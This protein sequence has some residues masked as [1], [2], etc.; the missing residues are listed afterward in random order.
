MRALAGTLPFLLFCS[1][2]GNPVADA[3]S[4]VTE[5][6]DA[7]ALEACATLC[8]GACADLQS[9]SSNCGT[10]G[11]VCGIGFACANAACG[12][13]VISVQAGDTFACVRLRIGFVAC[14]GR[15]DLGQTA[16]PP[17][18]ADDKCGSIDCR[19][20][21]TI[22]SG[23]SADQLC[24]GN[25]FGC[26][27]G[28]GALAC[29]GN[30]ALGQL[31]QG[32][33]SPASS[34]MPLGITLPSTEVATQVSCGASVACARTL[35]GNVYCWGDNSGEISGTTGAVVS[36][37]TKITFDSN[38]VTYVAVSSPLG[39]AHACALRSD[40]SVWCWG[41]NASGEL[42]HPSGTAG[43]TSACGGTTPYACNPTP[44]EVVPPIAKGASYVST[45]NAA[46]CALGTLGLY[47][48]GSNLYDMLGAGTGATSVSQPTFVSNVPSPDAGASA[49]F[50][51][52]AQGTSFFQV[53]I[54]GSSN[55]WTWGANGDG[56]LGTGSL[57]GTTCT[58]GTDTS[59]GLP[60]KGAGNIL[61]VSAGGSF[62][63]ALTT[64]GQV[65]A[66]GAND[67]G[68]LAHLPNASGSGDQACA[69]VTCNASPK[70]LTN[71]P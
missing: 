8:N 21:P 17:G 71:L 20:T 58:D 64:G 49:G 25:D 30:N 67:T 33:L 18:T 46:S 16:T 14:W 69:T 56:Q 15:N 31:G 61:S 37:P 11:H 4:D 44:V 5:A 43:D 53:A 27:V 3:G 24:L 48:W 60:T 34:A 12:D 38:D 66:W 32:S 57:G 40:K 54:D 65:L 1:G 10:C 52:V 70:A 13:D 41:A 35:A 68:Q 62:A 2:G 51:A 47:C 59:C 23:L 6:K 19:A 55:L 50:I 45:G 22:V 9:D 39:F 29:W 36:T 26:A 63:L 42:G 7:P 28:G